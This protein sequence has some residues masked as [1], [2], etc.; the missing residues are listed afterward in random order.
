MNDNKYLN[1]WRSILD[2]SG[3]GEDFS[4]NETIAFWLVVGI[5]CIA[6]ALIAY[7]ILG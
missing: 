4:A 6:I 7:L 1:E 2:E 3:M 5:S